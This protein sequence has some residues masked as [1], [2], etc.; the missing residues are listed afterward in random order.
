MTV[1][2]FP[3]T[4]RLT[5][6]AGLFAWGPIPFAPPAAAAD[7]PL[8]FDK[9]IGHYKDLSYDVLTD[10]GLTADQRQQLFGGETATTVP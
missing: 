10:S 3:S 7:K 4:I 9:S 5:L 6:L 1:T 8:V 2:I